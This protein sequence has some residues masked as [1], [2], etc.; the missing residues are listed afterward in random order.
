M[1]ITQTRLK[2]TLLGLALGLVEGVAK[3][4]FPAFPIVEVFGFQAAI[5]GAFITFK[6]LNN[7]RGV[8]EDSGNGE[9]KEIPSDRRRGA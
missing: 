1:A 9:V 8:S 2:V 6:T 7:I 5:A 4:A 3:T